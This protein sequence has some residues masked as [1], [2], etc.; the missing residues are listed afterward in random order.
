MKNNKQLSTSGQALVILL[1]YTAIAFTVIMFSIALTISNSLSSMQEEEGN[2]ALEIAES[3]VENSLLRLLRDPDYPGETLT[4]DGGDATVIV[5]GGNTKTITSTG[6]IGGF[7]RSI[8]AVAGIES[9]I[10]TIETWQEM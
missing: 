1:F 4:V 5:S 8:Q 10:I 3:G 6:V 7:S 2:H 9:G